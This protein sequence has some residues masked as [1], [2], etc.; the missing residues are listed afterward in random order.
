MVAGIQIKFSYICDLTGSS[1]FSALFAVRTT[2]VF[3]V[4][5]T[6]L[7]KQTE[8]TLGQ[9][10][11]AGQNWSDALKFTYSHHQSG[12]HVLH[13]LKYLDQAQGKPHK[14]SIAVADLG[15]DQGL[16]QGPEGALV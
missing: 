8:T 3:F 13:P 5:D 6:I 14:E 10:V 12:C 4:W 2:A 15:D 11:E 9:P 1:Y 7:L 16:Q